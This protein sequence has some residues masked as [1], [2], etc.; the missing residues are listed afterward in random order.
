MRYVKLGSYNC[1][2]SDSRRHSTEAAMRLSCSAIAL[3]AQP[4]ASHT[5][6]PRADEQRLHCHAATAIALP[7]QRTVSHIDEPRADD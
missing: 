4:T 5:D 3:P 1:D 7:A 6:E 2:C